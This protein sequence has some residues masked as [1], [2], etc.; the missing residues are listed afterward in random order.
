MVA[1]DLPRLHVYT[2]ADKH[3]RVEWNRYF[4][5]TPKQVTIGVGAVLFGRCYSLQ[6]R[7]PDRW[8]WKPLRCRIGLHEWSPIMRIGSYLRMCRRCCKRQDIDA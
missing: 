2:P 3:P 7:R 1:Q 5:G 4:E 8:D 6:W